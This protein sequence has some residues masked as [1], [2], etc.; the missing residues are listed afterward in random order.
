MVIW[1]TA[2]MMNVTQ[3]LIFDVVPGAPLANCRRMNFYPLVHAAILRKHGCQFL[4]Q[5]VGSHQASLK[6][7]QA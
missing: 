1:K 2:Q 6:R 3:I 5:N 7:T 4:T